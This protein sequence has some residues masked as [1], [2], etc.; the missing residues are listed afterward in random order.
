MTPKPEGIRIATHFFN[1]ESDIERLMVRL[2]RNSDGGSRCKII[3]SA[4]VVVAPSNGS[5]PETIS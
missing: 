1:N 3:A 4:S 2:A 5:R